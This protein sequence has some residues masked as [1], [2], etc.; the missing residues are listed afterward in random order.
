M[1]AL[2]RLIVCLVD[3]LYIHNIRDMKVMHTIKGMPANTLGLCALSIA[4]DSGLMAYP[5]SS[6]DGQ[7]EVYDTISL[8]SSSHQ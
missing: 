2:Q 4:N 6:T 3:S 1:S 7:L 5:G 8:V